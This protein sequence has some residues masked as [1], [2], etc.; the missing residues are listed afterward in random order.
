[1]WHGCDAVTAHIYLQLWGMLCI[2]LQMI[3]VGDG[4]KND[5]LM[6][7]LLMKRVD[8]LPARP[9]SQGIS[10]TKHCVILAIMSLSKHQSLCS[11]SPH[12]W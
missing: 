12:G 2:H 11:H 4:G 7:T 9:S 10:S 8:S 3:C 5:S 1:V 6:H